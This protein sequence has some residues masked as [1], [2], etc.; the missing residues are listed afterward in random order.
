MF[1]FLL[2][3]LFMFTC[4]EVLGICVRG[5]LSKKDIDLTKLP[6]YRKILVEDKNI[7]KQKIH[8]ENAELKKEFELKGKL[9]LKYLGTLKSM[10]KALPEKYKN[11]IFVYERESF[12]EVVTKIFIGFLWNGANIPSGAS[13][14]VGGKFSLYYLR[15][16]C[17]H[18]FWYAIAKEIYKTDKKLAL[19]ILKI[20]DMLF[21]DSLR[22]DNRKI[23]S[24][25][26]Y[27]A[28]RCYSLW[29]YGIYK[30]F[31]KKDKGE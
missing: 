23:T 15:Q 14:L 22:D 6:D 25:V 4:K 2:G 26:F 17:G 21:R 29:T 13:F 30:N 11:T 28:V 1:S 7:F 27:I 24:I 9:Q 31:I 8:I 18:D 16:S 5:A 3:A 10:I 20:A 12:I 19:K